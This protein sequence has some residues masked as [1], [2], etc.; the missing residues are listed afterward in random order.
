MSAQ[1]EICFSSY[2]TNRQQ[3]R[4]QPATIN[5]RPAR[6]IYISKGTSFHEL[7]HS[8]LQYWSIYLAQY[9]IPIT[10]INVNDD[11]KS[12]IFELDQVEIFQGFSLHE[13]T[14][15]VLQ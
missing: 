3:T 6:V 9:A 12:S 2:L 15:L 4:G 10:D 13:T 5:P 14:L 7:S 1:A 8:V 11:H